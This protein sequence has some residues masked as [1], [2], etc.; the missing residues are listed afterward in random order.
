MA[1]HLDNLAGSAYAAGGQTRPPAKQRPARLSMD[2]L[3]GV[4]I[5]S[6]VAENT[7]GVWGLFNTDDGKHYEK[8]VTNSSASF[9][10]NGDEGSSSYNFAQVETKEKGEGRRDWTPV[11]DIQWPTA[12]RS[13]VA[14]GPLSGCEEEMTQNR[15]EWSWEFVGQKAEAEGEVLSHFDFFWATITERSCPEDEEPEE[16]SYD[17][18]NPGEGIDS[19]DWSREVTDA[20]I[21][22]RRLES[23]QIALDAFSEF[24]GS[25]FLDGGGWDQGVHK[26]VYY[27]LENRELPDDFEGDKG[28]VGDPVLDL[29]AFDAAVQQKSDDIQ[30]KIDAAQADADA[31][32][33]AIDAAD[34][35]IAD[36]EQE[37][38]AN[39]SDYD[40][41]VAAYETAEDDLHA[42]AAA[43]HA[44]E[45]RLQDT[46]GLDQSEIDD[47]ES[48]RDAALADY[49]AAQTALPPL[50][51]FPDDRADEIEAERR[52]KEE[53]ETALAF[54]E[55]EKA[56]WEARKTEAEANEPH[57][58]PAI[59]QQESFFNPEP[60][61]AA[62]DADGIA[63]RRGRYRIAITGLLGYDW[64][65]GPRTVT[66]EW[67]EELAVTDSGTGETTYTYTDRTEDIVCD[68]ST[69]RVVTA[70]NDVAVPSQDNSVV[71]VVGPPDVSASSSTTAG[72]QGAFK[73]GV[74]AYEAAS[75][76][77][78]YEREVFSGGF[79]GCPE[80]DLPD[81]QYGGARGYEQTD[82]GN[83]PESFAVIQ[84]LESVLQP[85][86]AFDYTLAAAPKFVEQSGTNRV[87]FRRTILCPPEGGG[88]PTEVIDELTGDLEAEVTTE[89]IR[90]RVDDWVTEWIAWESGGGSFPDTVDMF[91]SID[92]R[93][94]GDPVFEPDRP[95]PVYSDA[96]AYA[97]RLTTPDE[98]G[99]YRR[100]AYVDITES[101]GDDT[102]VAVHWTLGV[103]DLATGDYTETEQSADV[104]TDPQ[105]D[106]TPHRITLD[107][108]E[109]ELH[110][111]A[112]I[113]RD[114]KGG[115]SGPIEITNIAD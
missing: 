6:Q 17:Q 5:V 36:L 110:W 30:T 60:E 50:P 41:D 101:D 29:T 98:L 12:T 114:P 76:P 19:I 64:S 102:T 107:P 61:I 51:S 77:K 27:D 100:I 10:G 115:Q 48:Q 26:A 108:P 47:L 63:E 111:V 73:R 42:K 21:E 56:F 39:A 109:G 54:A 112:D 106:T 78:I 4:E 11:T 57:Y 2:C 53:Q 103:L 52:T 68:G 35:A 70:W 28:W 80:L 33:A 71:R 23:I 31:A 74:Y 85:A 93:P 20:D 99:Y 3:P 94:E 113:R 49:Q 96:A 65:A 15:K 46:A 37:A 95:N 86:T 81:K 104:T 18:F 44:L 72:G 24:G 8:K 14:L 7:E 91:D 9:T 32:Q 69:D 88:E 43:Y 66:V 59:Q 87:Y 83:T 38:S 89:S 75:P 58:E 62:R 40:A 1:K 45:N 82:F 16:T 34:Q 92:L 67:R 55:A 13:T 79:P 25:V 97:Y 105:G 90:Q 84:E 22:A